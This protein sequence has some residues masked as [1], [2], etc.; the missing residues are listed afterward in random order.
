MGNLLK[1]KYDLPP[2]YMDHKNKV[3]QPVGSQWPGKK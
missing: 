3:N 2:F 1:R